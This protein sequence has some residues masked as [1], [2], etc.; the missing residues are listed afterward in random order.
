MC[1]WSTRSYNHTIQVMFFD[2]LFYSIYGIRRTH[3]KIIFCMN[4]TRKGRCILDDLRD[5]RNSTNIFPQWHMN[6][7]IRASWPVISFSEGYSF[8]LTSVPRALESRDNAFDAAP[9]AWMTVS[10]I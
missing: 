7:P 10:G 1:P 2:L 9:L 5:I 8:S 4:N 6:T 3:V